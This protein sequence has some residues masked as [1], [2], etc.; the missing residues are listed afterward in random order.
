MFGARLLSVH[1]IHWT[2]NLVK[3]IRTAIRED[4]FLTYKKDFY[5]RFYHDDVHC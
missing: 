3:N 2:L 1:N 5:Q 4:R